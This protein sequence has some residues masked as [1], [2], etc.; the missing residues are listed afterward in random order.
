METGR[1][2]QLCQN[3][4]PKKQPFPAFMAI[5]KFNKIKAEN[6]FFGRSKLHLDWIVL[7]KD[8]VSGGNYYTSLH[9]DVPNQLKCV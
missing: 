2:V 9:L 7:E 5:D 3:E 4:T 1:T 8:Q 6:F